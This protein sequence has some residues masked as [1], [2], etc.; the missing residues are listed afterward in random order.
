MKYLSNYIKVDVRLTNT[1][2]D[3]FYMLLNRKNIIDLQRKNHINFMK[4]KKV[5]L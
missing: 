4:E 3:Y 1:D 2:I 5:E